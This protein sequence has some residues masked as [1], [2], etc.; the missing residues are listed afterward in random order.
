MKKITF[1]IILMGISFLSFGQKKN[2]II[3][4]I[5]SYKNALVSNAAYDNEYTDVWNAIYIIAAE[6]YNTISRESESK[7]YIEANQNTNTFKESITIEIRGAKAPWRVSFQVNQE[8][9]TKKEDGTYSNWKTHTS[10]TL[11]KYYLRLQTRLYELLNGPI[12]LTVGLQ[13]KID[14]FNSMQNKDRKKILK[15]KHY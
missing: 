14:D 12:E 2:D 5:K 11:G 1:S 10:S 4:E 8:K 7:G 15:G 13:K 6:E 9:R 3:K